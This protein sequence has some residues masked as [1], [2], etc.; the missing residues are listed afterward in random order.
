[1]SDH[2]PYRTLTSVLF[3]A[4][5][6]R[7]VILRRG[8]RN[9]Y[10]LIAWNTDTDTFHP[11]QWMKG[12]VRLTDLSPSGDKLLYFAEQFGTRPRYR[13]SP[14]PYEPLKSMTRRRSPVRPGRKTPRYLRSTLAEVATPRRLMGSWTAISTPPYFSALAIWPSIGRWTGGG[15]FRH[16]HDILLREHSC[17]LVPIRNVLMP[18]T[19]KVRRWL[20]TGDAR[21]SAYAPSTT[22]SEQHARAAA[23]LLD[24][25]L[26]WVDWID[27]RHARD[28]LF[29]GDGR[30]FR[31]RGWQSVAEA[32]YLSAAQPLADFREMAFTLL[33]APASAMRW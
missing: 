8:P 18:A 2:R 24:A 30:I 15:T 4:Q 17:G 16:E 29:A 6:P 12:N 23:A 33:P 11:G 5:A 31:L 7:A 14:G 32:S 21:P 25:G 19:V 13:S 9:R 10:C 26:K 22:E 3:A 20:S 27:L 28:M 1:M